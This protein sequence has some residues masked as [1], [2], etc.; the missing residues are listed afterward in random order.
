MTI[1]SVLQNYMKAIRAGD[2]TAAIGAVQQ[3]QA[4]GHDFRTVYLKVFQ[5]ALEEVGRLWQINVMSVAEEHL[6]TAI[7]QFAMLSLYQSVSAPPATQR[8]L[9][10]ACAETERHDLGLRMVC[11]FLELEGWRTWYLGSAVPIDSLVGLARTRKPTAIALSASLPTHIADLKHVIAELKALK[12]PPFVLVG[13]RPFTRDASLAE[14]IG[15]DATATD[16]G[17]AVDVLKERFPA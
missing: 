15:A 10:A 8:S 14:L 7:T 6:A 16:A 17:T 2:R 1:E 12:N 11:D 5:P 9:V 3:A 4:A 13:G